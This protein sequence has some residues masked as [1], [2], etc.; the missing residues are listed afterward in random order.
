[1]P[2]K[3]SQQ[4]RADDL[5]HYGWR[6]VRIFI[7]QPQFEREYF[8]LL[9]EVMKPLARRYPATPFFFSRYGPMPKGVDDADTDIDALPADY[10]MDFGLANNALG[11]ISV[12]LRWAV[13]NGNEEDFIR[14]K[15]NV[16]AN[17][18]WYSSCLDYLPVTGFAETRAWVAPADRRERANLIGHMLCASSRLVLHAMVQN[19]QDWEFEQNGHQ[20]AGAV[21]SSFRFA[22]HMMNNTYG[23]TNGSW[24]PVAFAETQNAAGVDDGWKSI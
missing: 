15:L 22:L 9:A 11:H 2:R 20:L 24:H 12:R 13:R 18:N 14:Q 10:L 4:A 21:K 17:R 1:M 19:G 16:R 7:N 5:C 6:Q 23:R 8:G 3:S